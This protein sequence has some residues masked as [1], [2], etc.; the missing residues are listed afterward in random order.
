MNNLSDD[1]KLNNLS[2]PGTHDSIALRG[3]CWFKTQKM[4]I[5]E[6][7]AIGIRFFDIRLKYKN[8]LFGYHGFVHQGISLPEI[9]Y[10]F[11]RYLSA[12]PSETILFCY[13]NEN[14]FQD[15]NFVKEIEKVFRNTQRC[16]SFNSIPNLGQSRGK[17]I[18]IDRYNVG[19]GL[20]YD[21]FFKTCNFWDEENIQF[22]LSK[23]K[24]FILNIPTNSTYFHRTALNGTNFNV[25]DPFCI[26]SSNPEKHADVTNRNIFLWLKNLKKRKVGIITMDFPPVELVSLIIDFNRKLMKSRYF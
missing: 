1:I 18:L 21:F 19:I 23:I 6:Q 8:G 3:G 26:M 20:N 10:I 5:A 24:T 22:K 25:F 14:T 13:R 16:V 9:L 2:I 11:S 7:L 17:I 12:Y 4:G 15:S